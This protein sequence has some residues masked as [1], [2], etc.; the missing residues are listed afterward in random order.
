MLSGKKVELFLFP[1]QL[2]AHC[3]NPNHLH[4]LMLHYESSAKSLFTAQ[5]GYLQSQKS[6]SALRLGTVCSRDM[7]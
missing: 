6:L 3:G 1:S 4:V 2:Q 7:Q 5:A